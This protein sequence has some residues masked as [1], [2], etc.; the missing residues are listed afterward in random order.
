[1]LKEIKKRRG[2]I[3]KMPCEAELAKLYSKMTAKEIAGQF[4]VAPST[5]RG[6]ISYYRKLEENK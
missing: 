4:G 6:W 5:V 2:K 3:S 1:M